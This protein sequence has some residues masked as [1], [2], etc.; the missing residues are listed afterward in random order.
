MKLVLELLN[1]SANIGIVKL[2]DTARKNKKTSGV[3]CYLRLVVV[4][5]D[6]TGLILDLFSFLSYLIMVPI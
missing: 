5:A 6:S 1:Q 4:G 3:R 2:D